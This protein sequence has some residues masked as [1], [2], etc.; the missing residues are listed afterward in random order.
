MVASAASDVVSAGSGS[1]L[2][3]RALAAARAGLDFLVRHQVADAQSAD[4]GR[5][6][7]CYELATH[8]V[9]ARST[10]W[11]TGIAI[12]A[13]LAG[14]GAFGDEDYR[15]AAG[16]A[17]SYLRS[18]QDLS[19]LSP[20][21]TSVFRE[22]TPQSGM[23]HPR[24]A[25][26]AAWALLDW[27]A[28]TGDADALWRARTYAEWFI[29]VGMEKGYPYWTVRFDGQ[30]WEP[31]YC[32]SFH[33]G[34]AFFLWRMHQATGDERYVHA[35]RSI[36]DFYNTHHLDE[37]GRITVILDRDTL[38]PL[39]GKAD[40][41]YSNP[42]WEMMHVYNDDFGALANLAAWQLTGEA[43]YLDGAERFLRRMLAIQRDDGGFGPPEK[44]VPSGGGPVLMEL[45]AAQALGHRWADQGRLDRAAEYLMSIQV[46]T[47][48]G[49]PADGAFRGFSEQYILSDDTAN[50][51]AGAYAILA[52]LRYAGVTDR[53]YFFPPELHAQPAAAS[54]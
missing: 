26:T 32:G 38:A 9:I 50:I 41:R 37:D 22:V 23:A 44:S 15:K 7:F 10:N 27:S 24:D 5:F 11:T 34:S 1:S 17:V 49:D 31:T 30:P 21:V 48:Q 42:G 2:R 4:H 18:L 35:M 28:L 25:L 40:Q 6:P 45:L 16:R 8:R 52:L 19:T 54:R 29:A 13:M 33:S 3:E 39:D 20:R 47:G 53:Y 12:E 14:Y 36:L 46:R 43:S 51:R